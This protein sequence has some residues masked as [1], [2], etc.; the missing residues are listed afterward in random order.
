MANIKTTW[1]TGTGV[2]ILA[3]SR[4]GDDRFRQWQARTERLS[5]GPELMGEAVRAGWEFDVRS[6]LPSLR[7]PTLVLHREGNRYINVGAG[8]YLGEHIDGAKY[9]ELS[10]DDHL[11]FV[12]DVDA[13]VDEIEEFLTGRHQAPEGDVELATI[14]FTDIVDSTPHAARLGPRAWSKLTD[15][16]DALVRNALQRHRGREI[17]T[18]VDGF[19]ATFNGGAHAVRCAVEIVV[20][21]KAM[22]LGLRAGLH[23]GEIELRGDDIAGL[24]VVV[25]KRVC[26]LAGPAQVL[27][28]NTLKELLVG[29]GIVLSDHGVHVLKGVPDEW[30]LYGVTS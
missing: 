17:K 6:A 2:E 9:V 10:G 20:G 26:D 24:A 7:V 23:T 29:S 3:P 28:S 4:V 21:A 30:R 15:D 25:A 13:L 1:G 5:L 16:H 11:Y 12:G 19:L 27:V 14:L 22:G 18:M 8:R